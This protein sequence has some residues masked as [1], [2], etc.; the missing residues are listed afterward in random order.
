MEY[1][2]L[3]N[4]GRGG[5]IRSNPGQNCHFTDT[6]GSSN[7]DSIYRAFEVFCAAKSG[8]SKHG[9]GGNNSL[10]STSSLTIWRKEICAQLV[11]DA[12]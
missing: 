4:Y 1:P 7:P 8:I 2:A 3:P 10:Y 5:R 12:C 11:T 6:P 9:L